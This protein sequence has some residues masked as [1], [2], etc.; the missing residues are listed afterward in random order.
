METH[1]SLDPKVCF[2]YLL[3]RFSIL[4]VLRCNSIQFV[5]ICTFECLVLGI[6]R[7]VLSKATVKEFAVK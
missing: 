7:D 2:T 5:P 1:I 4:N 6:K 3:L